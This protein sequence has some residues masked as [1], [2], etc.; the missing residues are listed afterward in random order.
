MLR[1]GL[2]TFIM[3]KWKG[4]EEQPR[5]QKKKMIFYLHV[6]RKTYIRDNDT[7]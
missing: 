6:S 5:K 3:K 2:S 7:Y 4:E 1:M